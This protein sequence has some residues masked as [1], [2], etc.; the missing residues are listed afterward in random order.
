MS[1][2]SHQMVIEDYLR[3][4]MARGRVIEIHPTLADLVH[5]SKFGIIPK[6]HQPRKWRLIVDMS[7]P[8]EASVNDCIESSLDPLLFIDGCDNTL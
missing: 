6:K 1:A 5:V 3:K 7:A 4:K 8:E 2:D